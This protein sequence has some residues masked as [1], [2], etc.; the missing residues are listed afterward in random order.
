[1][2][3]VCVIGSGAGGAVAARELAEARR[4][5]V[6]VEDGPYVSSTDFVQREETMYPRLYREAGTNATAE[7]TVLVSQG[8]AVGGSNDPSL[9]LCAP[10]PRSILRNWDHAFDLAGVGYEALYPHL[11]KVEKQ[12][13]ARR[14]AAEQV[15]S[16]SAKLVSGSEHLG[17][18]GF[19]PL[20]NRIDCVESG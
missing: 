5:V 10:P 9:R 6:V 1:D 11:R 17:Y 19:L 2:A 18:R 16:N 20:H 12:I 14:I 4:S 15:N 13:G 3:D 8:R 7:Y